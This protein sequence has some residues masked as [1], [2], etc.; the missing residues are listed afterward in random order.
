MLVAFEKQ[1]FRFKHLTSQTKNDGRDL[2]IMVLCIIKPVF[3]SLF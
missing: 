2:K 1:I 3:N